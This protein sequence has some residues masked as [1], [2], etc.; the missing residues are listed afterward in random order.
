VT[1]RAVIYARFSTELQNDRSI[2]DQIALCRAE[3]ARQDLAVTATYEDRALS[4]ASTHGRPALARLMDDARAKAFDVVLIEAFDRLSGDMEDLAGIYKRLN[5]AGI[6]LRAV[7]DG[8]ANPVLVGIRGL[9]GQMRLADSAKKV[10]RG[11]AGVVRDGRSAGGRA[12]GYRPVRGFHPDGT[13]I[14][15]QL[16][17]VPA[18][19]EIIKR[20]FVEY[21]AGATP[22][23]I[24]HGLNADAIAPPRGTR[25]NASTI[26]GNTKRGAGIL[27]NELYV[28]RIVWNKVR[29]VKDPETGRRVS[30][31]NTADLRQVATAPHL[32]IIAADTWS[33]AQAVKRAKASAH[34]SQARRAPRLLSG[35]LRCGAC[36]GGMATRGRDKTGRVRVQCST[37]I[38]S[39]TCDNRR[40][41]YVDAIERTALAGLRRRFT[42]RK[43]FV[44]WLKAY[45]AERRRLAISADDRRG[46]LERRAGE[47]AREL[48]RA[49]DAIMAGTIDRGTIGGA[50]REREAERDRIAADLA[51][52]D[53]AGEIVALHPATVEAYRASIEAFE[54]LADQAGEAA[55]AELMTTLRDLIVAVVIHPGPAAGQYDVE[56]CGRIEALT[57]AFPTRS[58]GGALT[59]AGV[60]LGQ[61]PTPAPRPT[62]GRLFAFRCAAV[63]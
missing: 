16:E 18:E 48:A 14:R 45:N 6:E 1:A 58:T 22:R 17:I 5:F 27:H 20:I 51:A 43:F 60:R 33:K 35:L 57:G 28:G 61:S 55:R 46:R 38:E 4:S 56:V 47:I 37:F 23:T 9:I 26:N 52:I 21:I 40:M 49:A 39:G 13:A 3:A 50:I 36:G 41:P 19:A 11:L 8:I 34:P 7:H 31:D 2:A 63:A 42:E 30:R 15:G 32:V 12:Y 25:W 59:V 53:A 10:R 44:A 24:A 29:M 62:I 54:T